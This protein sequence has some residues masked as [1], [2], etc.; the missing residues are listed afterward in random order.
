MNKMERYRMLRNLY[1]DAREEILD[2]HSFQELLIAG[3]KLLAVK[4]Y[5]KDNPDLS[6]LD[7]KKF[8]ENYMEKFL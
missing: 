3:E 1:L 8:I 7:A 2:S 4:K 5:N 6:L